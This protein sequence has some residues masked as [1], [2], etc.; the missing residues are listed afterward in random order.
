MAS[1]V[2]LENVVTDSETCISKNKNDDVV[3]EDS[4]QDDND[5]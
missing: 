2:C 3:D 4:D 5:M 1:Y